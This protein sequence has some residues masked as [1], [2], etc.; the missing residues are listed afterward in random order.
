MGP[1]VVIPKG[2]TMTAKRYL[3]TLKKYLI[4]FYNRMRSIAARW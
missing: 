1:L 4:L 3:Q 2:G